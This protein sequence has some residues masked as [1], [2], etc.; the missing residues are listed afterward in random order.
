MPNPP[1]TKAPPV[2]VADSPGA[3]RI[4]GVG[5]DST[6]THTIRP[7]MP[8]LQAEI[9]FVPDLPHAVR[10][11]AAGRWDVVL[12][13]LG[14]HPDEDLHWWAN[15]LRARAGVPDGFLRVS[16]GIESAVDLIADIEQALR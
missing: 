16:V 14:D 12:T 5:L 9:E 10:R 7:W 6:V 4:L 1:A 2:S 8:E 15:A 13:V 11:L 3:I